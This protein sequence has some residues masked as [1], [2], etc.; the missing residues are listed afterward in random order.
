MSSIAIR[1]LWLACAG[2]LVT[3]GSLLVGQGPGRD[4]GPIQHLQ[5]RGVA[6]E[7]AG[8]VELGVAEAELSA[9]LAAE[10][11]ARRLLARRADS[12]VPSR[13]W[14]PR[15]V[16]RLG[17]EVWW[18]GLEVEGLYAVRSR[19][20]ETRDHGGYESYRSTWVVCP[21]EPGMDRALASLGARIDAVGWT[22]RNI[23][24]GTPLWWGLL[25]LAHG[26]F[27]RVTRGYM[28]WR[29]RL[30]CVLMGAGGP[31]ALLVWGCL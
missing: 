31:V 25:A 11:W 27:D 16:G 2:A 6:H 30:A 13:S 5:S 18:A 12:A 20:V 7:I 23:L 26:W 1:R 29:G 9:R 22:W 19:R 8:R 21:D 28:P 15:G 4:E 24:L 17:R 3:A 10:E 14:L